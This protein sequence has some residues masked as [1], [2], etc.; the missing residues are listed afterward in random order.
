VKSRAGEG[1]SL[2]PPCSSR[3]KRPDDQLILTT[4]TQP[5]RPAGAIGRGEGRTK[6]GGRKRSFKPQDSSF[7]EASNEEIVKTEILKSAGQE[8][9]HGWTL[10]ERET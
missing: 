1:D 2:R 10:I 5:Y 9:N 7:S 4:Q 8:F 6:R 3:K